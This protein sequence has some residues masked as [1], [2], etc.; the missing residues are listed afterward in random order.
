MINLIIN[1]L[2]IKELPCTIYKV[3]EAKL[4]KYTTLKSDK[5]K[6]SFKRPPQSAVDE[7]VLPDPNFKYCIV[8]NA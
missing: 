7:L 8:E 4:R 1:L 3:A 2:K 6:K 5:E